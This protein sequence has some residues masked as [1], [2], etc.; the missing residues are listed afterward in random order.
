MKLATFLLDD[1]ERLGCV[2]ADGGHLVDLAAGA[3]EEAAFASMLALIEAGDA[4]LDHAREAAAKAE[5]DGDHLV[6]LDQVK[7]LAPI[8]VPPQV[9][10]FSVFPTHI[11]QAPAGM[12]KL[13]A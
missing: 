4:A 7:L 13:A 3:T 11:R 12:Q 1:R 2:S 5:R 6:A 9:R 8:P 10:D